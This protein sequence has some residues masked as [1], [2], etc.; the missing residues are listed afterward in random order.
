M[1]RYICFTV[2]FMFAMVIN[3]RESRSL[4][5]E[6]RKTNQELGVVGTS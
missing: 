5:C 3:D 6:L 1:R 4:P 2:W